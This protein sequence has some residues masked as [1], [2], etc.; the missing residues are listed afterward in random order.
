M[1]NNLAK[2]VPNAMIDERQAANGSIVRVCHFP[3]GTMTVGGLSVDM[4]VDAS[5]YD[6][7]VDPTFDGVLGVDF[8]SRF[9]VQIDFQAK[10]MTLT[11][12]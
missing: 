9:N 3:A 4:P 5:A 1:V 2:V 8:L 6:M 10:I 11:E 12:H 7:T